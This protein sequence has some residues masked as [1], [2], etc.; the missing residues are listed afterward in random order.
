MSGY[1]K[2]PLFGWERANVTSI[3]RKMLR[4]FLSLHSLRV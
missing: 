3:L 2:K 4:P 1:G